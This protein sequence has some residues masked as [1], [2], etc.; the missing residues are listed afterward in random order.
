MTRIDYLSNQIE[1]D[2]KALSETE[3]ATHEAV[4]SHLIKTLI[5]VCEMT[6]REGQEIVE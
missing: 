4:R 6:G 1:V 3:G 2:Q 5:T